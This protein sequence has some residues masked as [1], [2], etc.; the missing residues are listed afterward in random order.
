MDETDRYIGSIERMLS[1]LLAFWL[2]AALFL[3]SG[4]GPGDG[5]S[6]KAPG[7]NQSPPA[8][9]ETSPHTSGTPSGDGPQE[10][11]SAFVD[12]PDNYYEAQYLQG[13]KVG[14]VNVRRIPMIERGRN[15][16]ATT[17]TTRLALNRDGQRVTQ[18]F[19]YTSIE[20]E[21]GRLVRFE[22][23]MSGAGG[24]TV[25]RGEVADGMLQLEVETEGRRETRTLAWNPAWGSFFA[26]EQSL[27]TSP[28]KPG[29][30][31]T[32]RAL[33]P[34]YHQVAD[35]RLEAFDYEKTTVLTKTRNLLRMKETIEFADGTPIESWKWVDSSGRAWKT[36]LPGGIHG[37]SIRTS[38]EVAMGDA[39]DVEFDLFRTT[40]IPVDHPLTNAETARKIVYR[41][42]L[43]DGD[44]A[45]VFAAGAAQAVH[46][47]DDHT[48]RLE[49]AR[50][51][52]DDGLQRPESARPPEAADREPNSYIQCDNELIKRLAASVA[53][54]TKDPA[55][56]AVALEQFVGRYV[57]K[58]DYST[59]LATAAEVARTRR[60]DCTEHAVLLAAL[61]RARGLPARVV[62]GLVVV[63]PPGN[64]SFAYHMWTEV[65]LGDRWTPLDA[66]RPVGGISAAHLKLRDT[67][68]QGAGA[69]AALL[70]LYQVLGQLRIEVIAVE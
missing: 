33:V 69:L 56:L 57:E 59:A 66:T 18:E 39:G 46:R 22:T 34:I 42:A 20:T 27:E 47:L 48:I 3:A 40:V 36:Q 13:I 23:R 49:V 52:L 30:T 45:K 19:V 55:Q 35:V 5:G 15:L 21:D 68:L 51:Q 29:E 1:H 9:G 41:V 64:R 31:R 8:G 67:N 28:P 12:D 63:G 50:Q 7:V 2:C 26:V 53:P 6:P 38:R 24:D 58:T 10:G 11:A 44:P 25:T 14:F 65:W 70:P 60:G 62:I 37:E 54:D 43:D 4:C 32:L 17:S 61:C 16:I